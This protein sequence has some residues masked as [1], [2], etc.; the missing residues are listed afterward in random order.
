ILS[1][2]IYYDAERWRHDL[3]LRERGYS[4]RWAFVFFHLRQSLAL[5]VAPLALLIV[6]KGLRRAF[7]GPESDRY[8]PYISIVLLAVVFLGL[9]W[10]LRLALGLRPLPEG[11]VRERLLACAKR[12]RFRCSNILVW[13]TRGAV[14]N[15]VVAGI[16]PQLRYVIFTDRLV[17]ELTP[18]EVEAVFGHEV[19]HVKHHH[20][21]FYIGFLILSLVALAG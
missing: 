2:A 15:A 11:P 7:P 3:P 10:I 17:S 1:W 9:P 12:L 4:G 5:L 8:L 19:G 14:A 18:D 20:M 16:V 6:D 21:F 13:N